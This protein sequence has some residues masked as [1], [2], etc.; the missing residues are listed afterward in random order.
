MPNHRLREFLA[1]A[2]RNIL[3]SPFWLKGSLCLK[4]SGL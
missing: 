3:L 2:L 1:D 4:I